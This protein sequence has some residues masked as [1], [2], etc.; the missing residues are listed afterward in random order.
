M[1]RQLLLPALAAATLAGCATGYNYRGG[2][3]DYYYGQPRADYRHADPYYGH[4]GTYGRYGGYG[5]YGH[6]RPFYYYDR[7]GRLVY[8]NPHGH[9]YYGGHYG[10][11][12]P[13]GYPYR[14]YPRSP[15]GGHRHDGTGGHGTPP[16]QGDQNRKRPPWRDFSGIAPPSV[17]TPQRVAAPLG[18][19][20]SPL[21]EHRVQTL[22][23]ALARPAIPR[24]EPQEAV[25]ERAERH[26][27]SAIE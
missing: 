23:P 15:R 16:D 2:D 8:A 10:Y 3:G 22:R 12:A 13:Y 17:D 20:G 1:L 19:S 4:Y 14:Y 24:A 6:Q 25:G 21:R 27:P 5:S 11:G 7:F 9:G 18:S 26:I